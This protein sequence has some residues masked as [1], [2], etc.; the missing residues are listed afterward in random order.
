MVNAVNTYT[1]S[2]QP[3]TQNGFMA[4]ALPTFIISQLSS[5]QNA[6]HSLTIDGSVSNIGLTVT[7]PNLKIPVT[8]TTTNITLTLTSITNPNDNQPFTFN[9]EQASDSSLTKIYGRKNYNVKMNKFDPVTVVSAKRSAT[10]VG[11]AVDLTINITTPQYSGAMIINFP[12]SQIYTQT[13]CSI[14]VNS[15]VKTCSIINSTAIETTNVMGN[16]VYVIKGLMNQLSF[17]S[18]SQF[19]KI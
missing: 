17:S 5:G 10:K 13:N 18:A 1:L 15:Q 11:I 19:D 8:S 16:G 12:T 6:A 4:I 7:S 9:I 14:T 3:M 2:I